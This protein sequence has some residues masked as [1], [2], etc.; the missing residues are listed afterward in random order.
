MTNPTEVR[1]QRQAT[2]ALAAIRAAAAQLQT[3]LVALGA[4]FP[5]VE[6]DEWFHDLFQAAETLGCAD[7][8]IPT[9]ADLT[10]AQA[11]QAEDDEA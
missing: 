6:A 4:A 7:Y 3:A 1:V 5:V 10:E 2:E 11:S 9:L 8:A